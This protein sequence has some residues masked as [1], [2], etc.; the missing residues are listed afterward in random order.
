MIT[1]MLGFLKDHWLGAIVSVFAIGIAAKMSFQQI[2]ISHL[3]SRLAACNGENAALKNSNKALVSAVEN[4]NAAI[5]L[6]HAE[7]NRKM[8]AAAR[9]MAIA[10]ADARKYLAAAQKIK[11]QKTTGNECADMHSLVDNY[12]KSVP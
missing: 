11:A 12:I 2:E 7:A 10:K 3:D 1:I 8:K 5:S 4:Q 9:A 6:L